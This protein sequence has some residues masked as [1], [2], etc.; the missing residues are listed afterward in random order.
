MYV[1]AL[2]PYQSPY[3]QYFA[4]YLDL[5][6]AVYERLGFEEYTK[7][8]G[9][10]QIKRLRE[11]AVG[12]ALFNQASELIAIIDFIMKTPIVPGQITT[13]LTLSC[14]VC[15]L[16]DLLKYYHALNEIIINILDSYFKMNDRASVERSLEIY[17]KMTGL[18]E[19]VIEFLKAAKRIQHYLGFQ[20]PILVMAPKS[21]EKTLQDHF[22][23]FVEGINY[24]DAASMDTDTFQ[25]AKNQMEEQN[26][27]LIDFEDNPNPVVAAVD[28]TDSAACSQQQILSELDLFRNTVQDSVS[29]GKA[30]GLIDGPRFRGKHVAEFVDLDNPTEE[31]MADFERPQFCKINDRTFVIFPIVPPTAASASSPG[32]PPNSLASPPLLTLEGH[33]H[34]PQGHHQGL[35]SNNLYLQPAEISAI[36]HPSLLS[37]SPDPS[38]ISSPPARH[39]PSPSSPPS[40][41]VSSAAQAHQED[42][43]AKTTS[44]LDD[45]WLEFKPP[46]HR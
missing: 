26:L 38:L 31:I 12:E 24:R 3:I 16:K 23:A 33:H 43:L 45:L 40:S 32:P 39:L 21:L 6:L 14:F 28:D 1:C 27:L 15:L 18:T 44:A 34:Q 20:V 37:L 2:G 4:R 29:E 30:L 17:K 35:T 13:E 22:D 42:H 8:I 46:S 19:V 11:T 41:S 5:K 7:S 10:A 9:D 36:S 25:Q